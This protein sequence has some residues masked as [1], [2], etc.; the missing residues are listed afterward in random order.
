MKSTRRFL[1]F[2]LPLPLVLALCP[3]FCRAAVIVTDDIGR[4]VVLDAPAC[5]IVPLYGAF[6][7]LILSL[8]AG[9]CLAARTAADAKLP[10]LVG[11]PVIGTHMRPNPELIAVLKPDVILHLAGRQEAYIHTDALRSLGLTVLAFTLDSFEDMFRVTKTLGLLLDRK[12]QAEA[13]VR[14]WKDRLASLKQ[15]IPAGAPV[16]VFYEARY[17][18]L[19]AAGGK[20]ITRD[21]IAAAGGE[22]V[23]REAKKLVRFSEEALLMADP[24]VYIVQQGPMNPAP[25]PP[26]ARPHYRGLAAVR[27]EHVIYVDEHR[28][29][30]PGP[31]SIDAAEELAAKIRA[32]RTGEKP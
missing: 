25:P 17:P 20:G 28:Y 26:S 19:L 11:L 18:N 31:R 1:H 8:G 12:E 13:R 29:A 15:S 9:H 14:E 2:I 24:D 22:N 3:V 5:R 23:T 6:S 4:A 30:R 10:E 16:R 7:E 27:A 32:V 21:I